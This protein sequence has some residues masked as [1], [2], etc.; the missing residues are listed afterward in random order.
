[1]AVSGSSD[2]SISAQPTATLNGSGSTTFTVHF[3]PL[4]TGL[5]A[6]TLTIPSD[7]P[8]ESP[9]IINLSGRGLSYTTDTDGDGMSDSAEFQLAS[10]G[11]DW[12]ASQ[13]A[14]VNAYFANANNNGLYTTAQ[15]Q[16][17]N[18]GVP[19]LQRNAATG[20]FTLVIGV[21]KTAVLGQPFA[22]FPFGV[23]DTTTTV[24][25]SGKVEFEFPAPGSA[26]FFRLESQ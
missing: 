9:F 21:K 26:A 3:A 13:P 18:V 12:Q 14:Q 23:P 24:N 6:A 2:F 4:T 19:L 11:F 5:K 25:G 20:K 8:D 15:V 17:L 7:D 1:V 10:L 16:S 22:D